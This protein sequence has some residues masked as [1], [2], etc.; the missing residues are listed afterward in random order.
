M[1]ESTKRTLIIIGVFIILFV[2]LWFVYWQST[3]P[4]REAGKAAEEF[5]KGVSEWRE[6]IED[7]D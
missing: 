6:E 3:R 4:Y 7:E 5:W 1:K 2:G